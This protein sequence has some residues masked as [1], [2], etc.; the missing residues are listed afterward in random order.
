MFL[1]PIR[2]PHTERKLSSRH[3]A[4]NPADEKDFAA[5]ARYARLAV[6]NPIDTAV[7]KFVP[8]DER[9]LVACSGGA[10]STALTAAVSGRF[11]ATVGHVDHGLRDGSKRDA[12]RVREL[13]RALGLPFLAER[14]EGVDV[15]GAGLE[16]AAREARYPALARLAARAGASL[17]LTAHTRRDQAETLLLRLIRGAGPQALASV[18]RRRPLAPGI[19]VLRPL[20]DVSR[21]DTEAYCAQRRLRFVD[22]PHN[23][24]PARARAKLRALWPLLLEL[25]P[26]LEEAL[27]G[28]AQAFAEEDQLL[29]VLASGPVE[30][31]HPAL[32]R[33]ALLREAVAAGV[34]PEREHLER[35]LELVRA[36]RGTV[37]LPSGHAIVDRGGVRFVTGKR[38]RPRAAAPVADSVAVGGPGRY[39]LGVRVLVVQSSG[40]KDAGTP[41]DLSL[42]P[43]PWTLRQKRPGD[44]F[45][46]ARGRTR[47]VS[48]WL[49]DAKV[50][51][52]ER[53]SAAVLEDARGR[54]FFV[55]GLRNSDALRP[56]K[57]AAHILLARK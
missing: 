1:L 41:V 27:S 3:C 51:P 28:F 36:G 22:D 18:R 20:L 42:A 34:R 50:P 30:R 55:E 49:A 45:R 56:G 38:P 6:G 9:L 19:D 24:D 15:R 32:Q 7:G 26:R 29:S 31:L 53:A 47:K 33:R 17:V 37:D 35:L 5:P 4:R 14:L 52:A 16:A 11:A 21:S 57:P 10:D 2:S 39:A 43:F 46:P 40:A 8:Q 48:D 44:R 23:R 13:A 25:N 12:E 54:V